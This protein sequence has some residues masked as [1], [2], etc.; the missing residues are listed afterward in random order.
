MFS[1]LVNRPLLLPPLSLG[2]FLPRQPASC[3]I[4]SQ[5][6][7][8]PS[9]SIGLFRYPLSAS[10]FSFL[11]NRP[12]LS[13]PVSLGLFLPR[14]PASSVTPSRPRSFP[15]SSTG[16]CCYPVS[17]SVFSF[18][19]NRPLPSPP[20]S[21][22]LFLH[23]NRPLL[24]P[25]L[26]LGLFLPRQ[27]ASSVTPFQS[28]SFPSSSTGL[29]CYPLSV[30]VFSFLVN[31]PL[32]SPP[33]SLGLFLPRQPASFLTPSQPL[34]FPSSSTGLFCYPLSASVFSFLVN[35]PL[36]SSPPSLGLFLPRQSASSV[37]PSQPRSFP[38][39][40]TGLFCHPLSAS[41][42]S[43]LVNRPLPLPPL[44]LGLFLPLQPASAVTPSQP[45]SF[46]SSS[47]GLFRH[48]L[49]ALVFS[50][51]ATGL[52][53]YPVSASV[54][55]FLVN[56]PLL[57]PPFSLGLFL[58]CQPASSVTP[59]Q[60]RS[61]P[62]S[63]TGLFRHP[64]SALVFS[65]IATG[66]F[67]YPLS[68]LVF[69]FLVNRPLLLPRLSLGLFLPRQPASSVTPSQP[70]SFTSSSTG[71]FCY[72]LSSSVF[73]FPVNRH[74]LLPSLSL[75]LFSFLVNRPLLLPPLS[76]GLFLPR[77]PASSVT[78]SQPLSFPSSSTGLFSDPLTA[79][80]FSFL[81]NRPLP[82][83]PL[84]LS[85][86]LP[87]QPA[88]SLTPS[89]PQSFPSSS[90]GLFRHSL[91][92]SVFSF[93]STG[94]FCYPLSVSV[95]SFLVN[96]PLP[97]PPLSLGLFLPRQPAPSVIPSQPRSFPSPST[98]IF[99]YPLSASVFSFLVNRPL[100]SPP[101]SLGLFLPRQPA[102]SVTPSQPRY[103]PSTST[104]LF[105]YPLSALVFSFHVNRPL[106]SPPLS[107]GLFLPPQPASFLTPSQPLCFPSSSTGLFCYP[108]SA[109]VF[110]FLVNRP[111]VSSPPSL[112]LFLPRQ[113]ASSVT[114]S[115]PRSF[116]SSS[117]GLF[118][119]P[120]SASVF[121]FLVNRPLPLPPHGLGLFLPLQP[122]SAVTPSQPRSFPSSS[123]GLF[124][125]P[126][127][128]LVFSFIVT[129]LFCYPVSASV[130]SFLVNRPLLLPPFSLGLFLPRQPASSVTPFQSRS[131][132]S[133]STGLFCHPLSA[134][135]FSFLVNRPLFSPP[136]SLCVF[137]PRQPASSVTPSQPRCF[138][139]SS[140]GLLSHPL[141]ASV[142]SFLV[143]R[144][145]P[146][147]PLSLGLFLP[148]QPA[149][150]VT[151]SQPRSFPSSSTG[152]FRY[153]LSASVFSFL[154]NRPLLLPR[155]SLGLFLPRQPASSVTP[156]QHWSFPSSQPA[157]SVTP[158]QPRSFPSSSTGL[159]CYPLSVSV[160]SFLV[161]RP[162][163]LPPFS[164]GLFLP[165][166]PASS[167][168]P[169]QHWSF[170]SSQPASSVTPSQPWSFPSSSTG[171][172]CYH[173]SAS[174]FSFLVNRPH[175]SP[176]LSLGLLLPRQPDPSVT[177]SH[178]RSFP[179]PS[180]GIFCYPLSASVS[181]PSSSTGPFCYPLSAS[182]FS[183]PVNR[184]LL[185]PFLSLCLF[186]PR[187]PAS[188][189]TPSQ[190]RSFPSSSTGLFRH[191][192]SASVFSFH[193]NRPLLSPP[194]SLSLFLPRQPASSVTPSQPRSFPSSQPASSVT[195]FQSRSFPSS[196]TGL[197]RLPLSA[198]VFSFLV[199]RPLLLSPL[200]L[201]L[202]LPRQP[203]SSVTLSQPLSF[204]SSSTGLFSHPLTASVFSFLV[205]RPLPSPP[206][207]LGIFLPRQ[208]ASSVTPSQRWS[209]PSS[210]TGLFCYLVSASVFSFLV[211]RPLLLPPYSLSLFL[212]LQP[213]FSVT[214]YQPR[215][216]T[217]SS[218]G[219]FC[220]PL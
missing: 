176:P 20:L 27:P 184:H 94:L 51:I 118:C 170:P 28:R 142:F 64:L 102:S 132:P 216:F 137:L 83:P 164:L 158:S 140:T 75:C 105:C 117:T 181:F 133:S 193:V 200:S 157:S 110:S 53:C 42:F 30:S 153:P 65:F 162:L 145:L 34:C 205:N 25:R 82:S 139:S 159:F 6:R 219:L 8:F 198:L 121:S 148:R 147:P 103:F 206:L 114:P 55:S 116:P 191:P 138:P 214:P 99:C 122:A 188:S 100:L 209:F 134:S 171:L 195:P 56:R 104:G 59:F 166:Q 40:S 7:S 149:S 189:L 208:P 127:S 218:N 80:V 131:F 182:V 128:A 120:L 124:R 87:R 12:L 90:T 26:S 19:V 136:L 207:S 201:G 11:V 113:S 54:F 185:L 204:P 39:S 68:A 2:V 92:T 89:Q 177:P 168:T 70:R 126:L 187:Q 169:S 115:Q 31:R 46:P 202:F 174:V 146:L 210:S 43:F 72:P 129:G 155:L 156:S 192:L 1:F 125:H 69:S 165:R 10:V 107:L 66:L 196:S 13:P 73:S 50:F 96:R 32:L 58:P 74:L 143:N 9:S 62:S 86:F 35:R 91:S 203:A 41:V 14:Q 67:C 52:F 109:S 151:P 111:L 36:V 150:S 220:H 21:I 38:S 190:P 112:G 173:V 97:S 161:N 85:I 48:P 15:S 152:L 183:F 93:L 186:L 79:S 84:S 88:S 178:P 17:A 180:T 172:F 77:Q 144:P 5:P 160:F 3:L 197:F 108:L 47:T 16:L 119:H 179:S 194:L 106:L 217:S 61:F 167:V 37:T 141:P 199:N 123:T 22:G 154:F 23:R 57:L 63:S 81:V 213:A 98:G 33:L 60:S 4:P 45:R 211:N 163:L 135:V 49:S 175:L 130:F 215:S 29:F 78:L 212:P 95:F 101:H 18:L 71:P 24:L 76:L 44:G